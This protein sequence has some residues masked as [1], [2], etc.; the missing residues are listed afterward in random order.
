MRLSDVTLRRWL[1]L[2]AV[3]AIAAPVLTH[4]ATIAHTHDRNNPGLYNQ[5]HDF[6]L[7]AVSS[8]AVLPQAVVTLLAISVAVS[9]LLVVPS[10]PHRLLGAAADPR[11]PPAR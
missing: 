11:A 9:L 1:L 2:L 7:Y 10:R 5:E 8:A 4:G 3:V 6:T